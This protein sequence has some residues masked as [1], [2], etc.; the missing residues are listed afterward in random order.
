MNTLVSFF[1]VFLPLIA[2]DAFWIGVVAKGFYA[3]R[4][5]FLFQVPLNYV[6]ALFFYPIYALA[7]LLLAV[8]PAL[9]HA[10]AVEALWRGAVLGL[11]AYAAYD[12]TNQATI[13]G[14]PTSMTIV[15]IGWGV[16]V[17]AVTSALAYFILHSLQH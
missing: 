1:A 7:I 17:T 3:E 5:G 10:S 9:A 15:D 16:L 4:M 11:A 13:A 2:L 6:P 8:E 14:W 12:L